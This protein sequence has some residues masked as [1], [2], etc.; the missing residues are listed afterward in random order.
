ML[1][2]LARKLA[3]RF[4]F[5]L[6]PAGK[7]RDPLRQLAGALE[8]FAVDAVIDVGANRGQYGRSLRAA[9]WAG[10]ILSIEP[11]PH[12]QA[13]L[14]AT[15]AVSPPWQVGPAVAV[16]AVD[17]TASFEISA[18]DDMSSLLPQSAA[19]RTLSPG[20]AIRRRIAVPLRRLDRLEAV[21]A[22]PWHRLFVKLDLQGGE[23]A[24]LDG[25][26][27]LLPRIVGLQVEMALV[28]LYRGEADWRS[29]VDRLAGAGFELYLLIPGYFERTLM[30]QVQVDGIFFKASAR[31]S[32]AGPPL[33]AGAN[34]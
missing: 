25:M 28:P 33:R 7:P 13:E 26:T 20:S 23:A 18:E 30:R 2:S 12:L 8:C 6:I 21:T 19:L 9:G 15:A 31:P 4:G 29:I 3:G 11:Q 22:T 14:A 24:A 32:L 17:D 16:G 5:E 27:T 34:V 1:A 10:P